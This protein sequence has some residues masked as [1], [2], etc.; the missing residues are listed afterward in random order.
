VFVKVDLSAVPPSLTLEEPDDT[1]SFQVTV[2]GGTTPGHDWGMLFGALVHDAA[3]RLEGEH[4]WIAVDAVRR[5]AQGRVGPEWDS[6]LDAML[7]YA[8]S[9]DWLDPNGNAIRAHVEWT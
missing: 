6:R 7:A 5:M 3:G 2:V 1:T 8:R 4:A 9:K